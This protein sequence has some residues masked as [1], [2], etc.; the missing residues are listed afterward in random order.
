M[1]IRIASQ[2][3]A[4]VIIIS[5]TI[6]LHAVRYVGLRRVHRAFSHSWLLRQS[7]PYFINAIFGAA[8]ETTAVPISDHEWQRYVSESVA[9]PWGMPP[10]DPS[11]NPDRAAAFR[12]HKV[13]VGEQYNLY[14]DRLLAADRASIAAAKARAEA[15]APVPEPAAPTR[16]RARC[17]VTHVRSL[18]SRLASL[19]RQ[20]THNSHPLTQ[21][22]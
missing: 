1:I 4:D 13:V 10:E 21:H 7:T 22:R 6:G 5:D 14:Q 19:S 16:S 2:Y 3:A 12:E 11:R 17:V 18:S 8:G 20:Y 9:P 15:P